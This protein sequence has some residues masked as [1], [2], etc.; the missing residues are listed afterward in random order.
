MKM[1]PGKVHK[2]GTGY[3]A[4]AKD[5]TLI[6]FDRDKAKVEAALG[7]YPKAKVVAPD[8]DDILTALA[9]LSHAELKALAKEQGIPNYHKMSTDN[10]K[11]ELAHKLDPGVPD[12]GTEDDPLGDEDPASDDTPEDN[13]GQ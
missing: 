4:Y 11:A 6:C 13:N 1:E 3:A 9:G 8:D 10:L 7:R 12:D 5:G 2:L